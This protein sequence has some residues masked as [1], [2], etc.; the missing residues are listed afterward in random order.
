MSRP[1]RH[2]VA[3]RPV[4]GDA[5]LWTGTLDNGTEI[6][7]S[8]RLIAAAAADRH[9]VAVAPL[10]VTSELDPVRGV[11]HALGQSKSPRFTGNGEHRCSSCSEP[12]HNSRTCPQ[13]GAQPSPKAIQ[14]REKR[15][16]AK[17]A[18]AARIAERSRS[19]VDAGGAADSPEGTRAGASQ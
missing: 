9:A 8:G 15:A 16:R 14:W 7:I 19:M 12:G 5:G 13:I 2:L 4:A 18:R 6:E 17:A 11:A 3:L 10:T 1:V